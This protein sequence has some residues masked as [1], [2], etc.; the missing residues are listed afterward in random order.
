MNVLV[1]PGTVT[2]TASDGGWEPVRVRAHMAE[3]VVSLAEHPG[4]LDGPAQYGAYTAALA[5]GVVLPPLTR[6]WALDF[7]MPVATWTAAP[8]RD[9]IDPRLLD[10][11]GRQV[12]GWACSRALYDPDVDTVVQV[13]RKPAT[14]QIARYTRD[15]RFHAGLGPHK[16]RDTVYPAV[17]TREITWFALADP[18]GL[19]AL[20]E[21]VGALGG[22]KA[23]GHG[24]VLRWSVEH[25]PDAAHRWRERHF[26]DP[27]GEPEAIRA[28]YWH[29]SRRM[30]CRA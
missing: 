8:S 21:R 19:L 18:A 30:P 16:A 12:W 24:R 20:L 14:G 23:H 4:A 13:R 1:E 26:P 29:P 9:G 7:T 17:F 10:A 15:R 27:D 6:A 3:P 11:S 22:S 2:D 5:A 25:D 28:P